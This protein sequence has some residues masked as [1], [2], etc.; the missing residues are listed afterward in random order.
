MVAN[1]Q[2][3]GALVVMLLFLCLALLK[4]KAFA[5]PGGSEEIMNN[6][7]AGQFGFVKRPTPDPRDKMIKALRAEVKQLKAKL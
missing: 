5:I 2:W 3:E 6:L 7:A 4:V 1:R